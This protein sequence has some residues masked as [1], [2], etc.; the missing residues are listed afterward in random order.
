MHVA[1]LQTPPD[2]IHFG[3]RYLAPFG[4][5][6]EYNS[7]GSMPVYDSVSFNEEVAGGKGEPC[8]GGCG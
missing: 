4:A 2:H 1:R 5:D 6:A 8:P 3:N 7:N